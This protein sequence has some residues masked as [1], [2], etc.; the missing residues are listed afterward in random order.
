MHALRRF[1]PSRSSP[2]SSPHP[3]PSTP[4]TGT[5][6]TTTAP[7]NSPPACC[8]PCAGGASGRQSP[9]DA[10]PTIAVDP[11]HRSTWY[12]AASS[13]NVWKTTNA[14]TTWT[15]IF[16]DYGS[17]S[18]GAIALDPNDHLTLWVG[19][20]ENNGQRSVGYGD[21]VY[22]S[23]DGGLSFT[24][25]GLKTSEHIGMIA[26]HPDDSRT[27]YV[28]AQGP[29][30]A[31][32]GERGLYRT[33]DGGESWEPVLEIDEHTGVNEVYFDPRNPD[34][35][36]A[37]SWQRRRHQ[38]TMIDGG[39]GSGIHKSTDGGNTWRAISR[40]L[41]SG[42]KGRIGMAIS[43][44]DPDVLYAIV[45]AS[46]G[47]GG[48]FRSENLGESWSRTSNYQS[49]RGHVLPRALRRPA[50]LRPDLL[51]GHLHGDVRGRRQHVGP[52]PHA[53]SACRLPRHG[54]RPGRSR[55]PHRRQRRRALRDLRLRRQ[56]ASLLQPSPEPSST[57]SRPPAT[58]PSTTSTEA[59]RTT[60]RSVGRRRRWGA[61][62]AIRTGT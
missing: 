48:T 3:H 56:L 38:W 10:S 61:G 47:Q 51:A 34:V 17:Y 7:P 57:R 1:F 21:G 4:R 5:T 58:N 40:G 54:L 43:P 49:G 26:V 18:I 15:P 6:P 52:A 45:E 50:P 20:G 44:I 31:A 12:V 33:R 2:S 9:R 14:G 60:I 39:P 28:A 37:T 46:G 35:M 32:G 22:K 53:R 42:D 11:T 62:S 36:Y 16:D 55:A 59:P 19:T 41:P 23:V 27:V 13:G 8:P 24:N 30:W 29:L 25:M